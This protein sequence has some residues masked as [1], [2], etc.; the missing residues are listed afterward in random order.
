MKRKLFPVLAGALALTAGIALGGPS[1]KPGDFAIVRTIPDPLSTIVAWDYA[2]IDPSA[3]R[4]F[5]ATIARPARRG[6][7]T[8]LDLRS[9]R[10]SSLLIG[11]QMPHGTVVLGHGM[12]A[13]ADGA[14][15]EVVFFDETTGRRIAS[16]ATGRPP[17]P[18]GWHNPDA[19]LLEPKTG[20]LVAV[21]KDSSSLALVDVQ[22]R[23]LVDT[24]PIGGSPEFLAARG[25][26]TVFINIDSGSSIDVVDIGARKVLK[27][28]PLR[29]CEEPTGLAYDVADALVISVCS[30]GFAKFVSPVDG[31][32]VASIAVAKGADAVMYDAARRLVFIAG[33]DDGKLSVVRVSDSHHIALA[34]TLTT[35]PGVRLGV[36][37]PRTGELYLPAAKSDIAAPPLHLPGLPP[38]PP[39]ARGS[40]DFLVVAQR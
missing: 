34:Q 40:F 32:E 30:N 14:K 6:G 16:V 8:V 17:T 3:G 4:L 28:I 37:D 12:M 29:D 13:L 10:I 21:N 38:I 25:D 9:R 39:A 7:V 36:I 24:I 18:Q 22:K 19:L 2:T 33:G 11:A 27:R 1:Q 26:G 15:S 5:L 35:Q 31:A 23:R 20:L